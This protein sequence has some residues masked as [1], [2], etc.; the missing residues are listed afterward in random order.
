[1]LSSYSHQEISLLASKNLLSGLCYNL[2]VC[3]VL[4]VLKSVP[5]VT[6]LW[7]PKN[8]AW[9]LPSSKS[10][11]ATHHI[12]GL[13]VLFSRLREGARKQLREALHITVLGGTLSVV[14]HVVTE[15]VWGGCGMLCAWM[16]RE[17]YVL[18]TT[19]VV[20]M[21][22]RSP[23]ALAAFPPSFAHIM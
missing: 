9:P 7:F 2:S 23:Q 19:S 1:M 3:V 18:F 16:N 22:P 11:N 20:I 10:P 4:S 6:R 14:Y 8:W 5:I 15:A 21:L 13:I 17:L 12:S